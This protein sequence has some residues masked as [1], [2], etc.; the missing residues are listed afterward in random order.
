MATLTIRKLERLVKER[1]RIRAVRHGRSVE[2]EARAILRSVTVEGAGANR[3]AD[4]IRRRF[5]RFGGVELVLPRRT[6]A[7]QSA[8][9]RL[10]RD[11]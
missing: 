5:Q 8:R 10:L 6:L 3:I 1:L 9:K 11:A 4:S 7:R 2:E